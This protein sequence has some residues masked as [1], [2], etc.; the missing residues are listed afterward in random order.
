MR[1]KIKRRLRCSF[2]VNFHG[3]ADWEMTTIY[4]LGPII[5]QSHGWYDRSGSKQANHLQ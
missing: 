5:P 1:A 4:L 2:P 3:M